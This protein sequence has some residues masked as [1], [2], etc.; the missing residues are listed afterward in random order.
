[1]TEF[2]AVGA[3]LEGFL[4]SSS[5]KIP[6]LRPAKIQKLKENIYGHHRL[7]QG[8]N[9]VATYRHRA[10]KLIQNMFQTPQEYKNSKWSPHIAKMAFFEN[11]YIWNHDQ[12]LKTI[13]ASKSPCHSVSTKNSQH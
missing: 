13:V 12:P 8:I 10:S 2:G 4:G 9:M 5:L 3:E 1:M 11:L 7:P 6:S